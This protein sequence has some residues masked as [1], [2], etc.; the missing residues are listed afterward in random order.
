MVGGEASSE[1]ATVAVEADGIGQ[2]LLAVYD[3]FMAR[4]P[5][6]LRRMSNRQL[7]LAA[8]QDAAQEAF[9]R[10]VRKAAAGE[11]DAGANVTAYLQTAARNLVLDQLRADRRLE[12][13]D[14]DGLTKVPPPR[15]EAEEDV[16]LLE[17]L[18]LPAIDA[19]PQSGRQQV[20][21]LQSQGLTD[22]EIAAALGMHAAR[23][24]RERYNA[25]IELRGSLATFIRHGHQKKAR[26]PKKDR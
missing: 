3:T 15:V 4:E 17:D 26:C 16:D 25:V 20:V 24:H 2:R 21:W 10:V 7:S 8:C 5:L 6:M 11:L 22:I 14:G 1:P 19:M 9:I 13:M 18:V 12:L 23:V